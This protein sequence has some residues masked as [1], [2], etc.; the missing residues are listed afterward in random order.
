MKTKVT[1]WAFEKGSRNKKTAK[2][3]IQLGAIY[4]S[5]PT[6]DK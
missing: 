4:C 3:N 5:N 2:T 6:V 1:T